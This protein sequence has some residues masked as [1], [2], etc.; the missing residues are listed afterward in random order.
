MADP[1]VPGWWRA[2]DHPGV[3]QVGMTGMT[4][5]IGETSN[6]DTFVTTGHA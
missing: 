1:A 5:A 3:A 4:G 2:A 6:V